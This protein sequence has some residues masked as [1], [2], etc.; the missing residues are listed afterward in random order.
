MTQIRIPTSPESDYVMG[1]NGAAKL[2]EIH[3]WSGSDMVYI[4][5]LNTKGL[6]VSNAGLRFK[7]DP[8]VLLALANAFATLARE[9][10][11]PG[12]EE[13]A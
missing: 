2:K 3:V 8:Q 9:M 4:D 13:Q 7:S 12:A 5:G 10:S 6:I 11:A 1:R